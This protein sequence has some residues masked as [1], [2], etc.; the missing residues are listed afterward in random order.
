M[1]ILKTIIANRS[2][3]EIKQERLSA[4]KKYINKIKFH[5]EYNNVDELVSQLINNGV[6]VHFKLRND[7]LGKSKTL[8]K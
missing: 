8:V 5:D 4:I 6:H 2:G 1:N 3:Y 7:S